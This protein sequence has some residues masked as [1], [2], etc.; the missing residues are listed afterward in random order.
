MASE[1][2]QPLKVAV[3]GTGYVGLTTGVALAYVCASSDCVLQGKNIA[4]VRAYRRPIYGIY[5]TWSA[6]AIER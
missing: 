4:E 2:F 1:S 5:F 6:D 3:I